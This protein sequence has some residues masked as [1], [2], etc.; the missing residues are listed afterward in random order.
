MFVRPSVQPLWRLCII[1]IICHYSPSQLWQNAKTA[2]SSQFGLTLICTY[3]IKIKRAHSIIVVYVKIKPQN[4]IQQITSCKNK[5]HSNCFGQQ[6]LFNQSLAIG[7]WRRL[8]KLNP[9][10]TICSRLCW[11]SFCDHV[12]SPAASWRIRC[13]RWSCDTARSWRLWKKRRAVSRSW[14]VGR[15]GSSENWRTSWAEPRATAR[16]CRDSSRRWWTL[17]TTC[18]T[19]APKTEVSWN[20]NVSRGLEP[21]RPTRG[22]LT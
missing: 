3:C 4:N 2:S 12:F 14:W 10:K 16:P 15:A 6:T 18:C 7:A 21:R 17:S 19:S 11:R 1:R 5:S 13:R 20:R 22:S 9:V 8:N